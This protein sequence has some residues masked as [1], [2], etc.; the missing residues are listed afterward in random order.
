MIDYDVLYTVRCRPSAPP[1]E[2]ELALLADAHRVRDL[3]VHGDCD[4]GEVSAE[5]RVLGQY[6][7]DWELTPWVR[8]HEHAT[9]AGWP[10]MR[11]PVS[12]EV[13]GR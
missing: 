6:L 13:D 11:E 10:E 4:I 12:G 1:D 9:F 7:A 3:I 8:R 5:S 2:A